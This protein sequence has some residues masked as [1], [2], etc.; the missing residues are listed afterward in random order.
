MWIEIR[1]SS[2]LSPWYLVIV[3][4]FFPV[5]LEISIDFI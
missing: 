5:I 2:A 3:H 4:L 1:E